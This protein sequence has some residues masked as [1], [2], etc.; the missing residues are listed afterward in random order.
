[1][2]SAIASGNQPPCTTLVRFA[3]KKARST[4]IKAAA[5][6]STTHSGFFQSFRTTT[7]KRTVVVANVPVTAMP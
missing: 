3:E 1:M 2:T 5:P 6:G 4:V 7:K